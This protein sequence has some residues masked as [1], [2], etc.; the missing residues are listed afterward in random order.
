MQPSRPVFLK[1]EPEIK[2]G[3]AAAKGKHI[4]CQ[5]HVVCLFCYLG[6]IIEVQYSLENRSG[7]QVSL[8]LQGADNMLKRDILVSIGSKCTITGLAQSFTKGRI[9]LKLQT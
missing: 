8:D 9:P 1:R 4:K 3:I 2:H 5:R 6:Q 7:C